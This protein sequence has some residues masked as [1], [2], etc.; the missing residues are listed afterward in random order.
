MA[1]SLT[2]PVTAL[3]IGALVV[4]LV[5]CERREVVLDDMIVS[6]Q[7]DEHGVVCYAWRYNSRQIHC[8]KVQ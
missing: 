5:G 7:P 4:A 3:A 2:R 1:T 6:T 8:V